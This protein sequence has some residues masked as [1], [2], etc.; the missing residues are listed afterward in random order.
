MTTKN[1]FLLIIALISAT[2]ASDL[3][4]NS[5][6]IHSRAELGKACVASEADKLIISNS[7]DGDYSYVSKLDEN[8]NFIYHNKTIDTGYSGN[9]QL[10]ESKIVD[11][12]TGFILYHKKSGS[13]YLTQYK[14]GE[15][16]MLKK[17]LIRPRKNK[18]LC[19][20]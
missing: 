4:F 16:K 19:F 5:K 11:G 10:T 2:L 14:D 12:T 9:A 7:I 6:I 17:R 18:L 8:G 1:L 3:D 20:L 15:K 13:E